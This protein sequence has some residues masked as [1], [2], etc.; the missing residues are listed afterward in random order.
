MK[1]LI[2][3]ILTTAV[4]LAV[5]ACAPAYASEIKSVQKTETGTLYTFTDNTGYYTENDSS[6][7][8]MTGI[9][10]DIEYIDAEDAD[11]V[12]ITCTNGNVFSWYTDAGDYTKGDLISC[13]M[14]SKGTNKIEDDEV[15]MARYA[16]TLKQLE[17]NGYEKH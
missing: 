12:T 1:K 15:I 7:Y 4:T 17:G 6:L 13:I 3:T 14:D 11:E 10:T 16:G 2:A 9:V 5:A 8:P